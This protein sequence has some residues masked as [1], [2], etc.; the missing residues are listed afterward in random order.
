MTLDR[1]VYLPHCTM[2]PQLLGEVCKCLDTWL[3]QGIIRLSQ[4]P[5]ASQVVRGNSSVCGLLET[6]FHHGK[7][8]LSTTKN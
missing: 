4:S 6:Q 1:T 3:R 2:P 5:Y 8:Y 7:R